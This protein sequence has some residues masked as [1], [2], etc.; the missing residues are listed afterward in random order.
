MIVGWI[1]VLPAIELFMIGKCIEINRPGVT[2]RPAREF[3]LCLQAIE[4]CF[5]RFHVLIHPRASPGLFEIHHSIRKIEGD[6]VPRQKSQ[7]NQIPIFPV[8]KGASSRPDQKVRVG[9][10]IPSTLC[11]PD[12]A[13]A[14][15]NRISF[16]PSLLHDFP[17]K[18]LRIHRAINP[19]SAIN[20]H[21]GDRPSEQ[22]WL[23]NK[24]SD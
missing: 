15:V 19:Q 1:A 20:Q 18:N 13:I 7:T 4:E 14:S 8:F 17:L 21:V 3:A 2:C 22:A 16:L 6:E 23:L 12:T 9:F 10:S 11:K 5:R 24:R